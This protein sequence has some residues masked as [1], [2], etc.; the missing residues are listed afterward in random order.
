VSDDKSVHDT[1]AAGYDRVA[2]IMAGILRA[3]SAAGRDDIELEGLSGVNRHTIK[4]YRLKQRK[5]SLATSL[6]LVAV[7]GDR[8]VNVLLH[9]IRYQASPLD[10]AGAIQPM[11]IVSDALEPSFSHRPGRGRQSHRPYRGAADNRGGGH[12]HRDGVAA[13]ERGKGGAVSR[14]ATSR[15]KVNPC[16]G[17]LAGAA[18][19]RAD[20]L[21]D[22]LR[23]PAQPRNGR[24]PDADPP[25][26]DVL[27]L[28]PLPAAGRG[29]ARRRRALRRR[30]PAP[31]RGG[32]VARRYLA[33]AVRRRELSQCRGGSRLVRRPQPAAPA[34]LRAEPFPGR[35]RRRG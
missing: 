34:A 24:Q 4:A 25:H 2:E 6:S 10:A 5:P 28:E 33:A 8:A 13:V 29:A 17:T 15:L 16:V 30:W 19:L 14:A 12:A 32:E 11:Q 21:Q 22:R 35:S 31:A 9:I 7:L 18:I 27:G 20:Q 23:I 3:A 1:P 26:R